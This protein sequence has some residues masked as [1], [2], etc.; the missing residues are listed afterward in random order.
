MVAIRRYGHFQV[1]PPRSSSAGSFPKTRLNHRAHD[2]S[3]ADRPPPRPRAR[4]S[5][6]GSSGSLAAR[7]LTVM[8]ASGPELSLTSA[9]EPRET[10]HPSAPAAGRLIRS[11]S[12]SCTSLSRRINSST[13]PAGAGRS[14]GIAG[15]DVAMDRLEDPARQDQDLVDL[16]PADI[17]QK[18]LVRPVP[19]A[20]IIVAEMPVAMAADRPARGLEG[21]Q[22]L[23]DMGDVGAPGGE[24][25]RETDCPARATGT[26]RPA[27]A[28]GATSAFR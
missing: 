13:P 15:P 16:G 21:R 10:A 27:G 25:R 19:C 1:K 5:I 6:P 4:P 2:S 12:R 20:G 7:W 8:G 11:G 9:S 24:R 23:L 22:Q 28:G 17:G 26:D 3:Q 14:S 18:I